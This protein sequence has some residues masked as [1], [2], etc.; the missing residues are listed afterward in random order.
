MI[1]FELRKFNKP[2]AVKQHSHLVVSKT[3][4]NPNEPIG[5]T[6]QPEKVLIEYLFEE[7]KSNLQLKSRIL[8]I[9][10]YI[11]SLSLLDWKTQRKLNYNFYSGD[12]SYIDLVEFIAIIDIDCISYGM[13]CKN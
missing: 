11:S 1:S 3:E 7:P 6:Y 8:A 10:Y 4:N 12:T 13:I 9:N 5:C 2:A